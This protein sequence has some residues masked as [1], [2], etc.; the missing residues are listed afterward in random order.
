M[1]DTLDGSTT[2]ADQESAI[3]FREAKG[4]RLKTLA[5]DSENPPS[6]NATFDQL[7]IGER[8]NRLHLTVDAL[9]SGKTSVWDGKIYVEGVLTDAKAYRD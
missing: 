8:P 4:Y 7:P 6:N 2:L 5:S 3:Q 9:P 1:T